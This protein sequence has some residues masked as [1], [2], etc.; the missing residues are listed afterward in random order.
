MKRKKNLL[1]AFL[2]LFFIRGF[3]NET[4]I[5]KLN[6]PKYVQKGLNVFEKSPLFEKINFKVA[7]NNYKVVMIKGLIEEKNIKDF[8]KYFVK[9]E[10]FQKDNLCNINNHTYLLISQLMFYDNNNQLITKRLIPYDVTLDLIDYPDYPLL[11]V[12]KS[13]NH[14]YYHTKIGF[15]IYDL[16][17]N[18]LKRIK[19]NYDDKI[20]PSVDS[21]F[22]CY[23]RYNI[24]GYAAQFTI[25]NIKNMILKKEEQKTKDEIHYKKY[26]VKFDKMAPSHFI[27]VGGESVDIITVFGGTIIRKSLQN[28]D[29]IW[30]IDY[31]GSNVLKIA[32]NKKAQTLNALL[33]NHQHV[34]IDAITGSVLTTFNPKNIPLVKDY[35]KTY[36][37]D[38]QELEFNNN[39]LKITMVSPEYTL[40]KIHINN[41]DS[42]K[43]K[44]IIGITKY[45]P[46]YKGLSGKVIEKTDSGYYILSIS[47]SKAQ[48]FFIKEKD[49]FK[50]TT[51]SKQLEF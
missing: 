9:F 21:N 34:I 43:S 15:D 25:E 18:L 29:N 6:L 10:K 44:K 20:T 37:I 4:K 39:K 48:L 38:L 22:V 30:K 46:N 17:G 45:Q 32:Y 28:Q 51:K 47:H 19:N 3:T 16:K 49:F 12:T 8:D 2:F 23:K 14:G 33:N 24:N 50:I 5:L 31:L 35:Y 26:T 36:N 7:K 1:I 40:I 27:L 13:I 41:W 11:V 42:K